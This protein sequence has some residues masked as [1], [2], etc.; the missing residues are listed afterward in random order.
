MMLN[1]N[2]PESEALS[3]EEATAFENA[4]QAAA[5][6]K[7]TLENWLVIG[8]SVMIARKIADR[9]PGRKTFMRVIEQQ[10]LAKIVDK[11]T[12]S[13]LE[14]I[15]AAGESA[16]GD[17]VASDADG[18]ATDR[19]GFADHDLQALPGVRQA[20]ARQLRQ[21]ITLGSPQAGQRRSAR[22]ELSIATARG[23][24]RFKV[25]DTADDIATVLVGMFTPHKAADIARR[26]SNSCAP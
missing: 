8:K 13:R 24:D 7:R 21:A 16:Q 9:R 12:A 26:S 3:L 1:T 17:N 22:G 14:R 19:L 5:T 2:A 25:D 6:L 4:C 23:C 15:M 11:S 20:K 10:G 18:K